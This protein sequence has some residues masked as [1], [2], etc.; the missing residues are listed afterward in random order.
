MAAD[1]GVTGSGSGRRWRIAYWGGAALLLLVPLAAMRFTDEVTWTAFDFAF[2][3]VM[4]AVV[5]G[6]FELAVRLVPDRTYRAAVAV[7]LAAMFLLVW[8]NGAVGLIGSENN[9][10]N[11]MYGGVLAIGIGGAFV[12]RFR[13]GGMVYAMAAMAMAQVAVA[14]IAIVAGLGPG[15]PVWPWDL[16]GLTAVFT[17]L[18]V[19]AAW[20][21]GQVRSKGIATVPEAHER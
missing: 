20:L 6:V 11:L 12:A 9:P 10:A 14:A 5:G 21:F 4:F 16:V 1:D 3:A 13:A 8:I 17:A 15:A 7:G 2:A 19:L 18:W